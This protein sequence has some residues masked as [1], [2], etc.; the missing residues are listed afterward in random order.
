MINGAPPLLRPPF[1]RTHEV[2]GG[3]RE[4]AGR[5]KSLMPDTDLT[6]GRYLKLLDAVSRLLRKGKHRVA[7]DARTITARLGVSPLGV[8]GTL[9]SWFDDRLPWDRPRWAMG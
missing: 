6:F 2:R 7:G 3:V 8:A 1:S 5:S 4:W 9:K